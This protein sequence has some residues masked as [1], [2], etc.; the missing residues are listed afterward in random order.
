MM[1]DQ[2]Y[3][4]S[5]N[6][7]L[8]ILLNTLS[9]KAIVT[10]ADKDGKI[11]FVSD[12]FC[13]ISKFTKEELVGLNFAEINY[14][15]DDKELWVNFWETIKQGHIWTGE[16]KNKTKDGILYWVECKVHPIKNS[17]G[18]L[19]SFLAIKEDITEKRNNEISDYTLRAMLDHI[20]D[21]N[22]LIDRNYKILFINKL[23]RLYLK[24]QLKKSINVQDNI[25]DFLSDNI[26]SEFLKLFE[27][28][29][30]GGLVSFNKQ[31]D[32]SNNY[33][34]WVNIQ[35]SSI[36][37]QNGKHIGVAI[38]ITNI[39]E[40]IKR[41]SKLGEKDLLN[42]LIVE[43]AKIGI[44]LLDIDGSVISA[45][46]EAC[47]LLNASEI[48]LKT[49]NR[50]DLFAESDED[51]NALIKT[52]KKQ[53]SYNGFLNFRRK[54]GSTIFCVVN[55]TSFSTDTNNEIA[56]VIFRDVTKEKNLEIELKKKQINLEAL[57]NNTED[58]IFSIDTNYNIIEFNIILYEIA[59]N[60]NLILQ[61]GDSIFLILRPESH[62][63]FKSIYHKVLQ[64]KIV[65]DLEQFKKSNE[66]NLTYYETNYH[67]IF[68]DEKV[69]GISI[70]SKNVT[71]RINSEQELKNSQVALLKS[72]F[73]LKAI[74]DS[75][76]NI[77]FFIGPDLKV[78]SYNKQAYVLV[79]RTF[80]KQIKRGDSMLE[81]VLMN[82]KEGFQNN[83]KRVLKGESFKVEKNTDLGFG[84][85]WYEFSYYPVN[86]SNNEILGVSFNIKNITD[87]KIKEIEI[88]NLSNLLEST[89][90][91]AKIGS[92]EFNLQTQEFFLTE[93]VYKI[94]ELENN[95]AEKLYHVYLNR[96]HP[97][98]IDKL[99][100]LIDYVTKNSIKGEIVHRVNCNNN[101]IKYIN[102]YLTPVKDENGAVIIIR[103]LVKDITDTK[104]NE[105]D[106]IESK[107]YNQAL[108][109]STNDVQILL[110][111]NCKII[112]F[113]K[114]AAQTTY[115]FTR[116]Q[117]EKNSYML[118]YIEANEKDAFEAEF[119]KALNGEMVFNSRQIEVNDNT[120]FIEVAFHP[121]IENNLVK[122]IAYNFK[123]VSSLKKAEMEKNDILETLTNTSDNAPGILYQ[124]KLDQNR[125]GSYPFLSKRF[126]DIFDL[127]REALKK[128]ANPLLSKIHQD[129]IKEFNNSIA[130]SAKNLTV[131]EHEFRAIKNN[132][133]LWLKGYSLPQH[134]PNGSIVWSGNFYDITEEKTLRDEFERLSLVARHT[135]NA[136]IMTNVK[137]EIEWVNEGYTKI[138]G[139]SFKEAIG[140]KLSK[141]LQFEI[142]DENIKAFIK[143]QLMHYKPIQCEILNVGK[144]G[145]VYWLD[146]DIQAL[147]DKFNKHIGY[148]IIE[149]DITE[150]KMLE[151]TLRQRTKLL[152]DSNRLAKIGSWQYDI[153]TNK[154]IW[155]NITKQIHEIPLDY[156]PVVENAITFYKNDGSREQIK[157]AFN[158]LLDY[159]TTYDLEI[160][161]ITP[162]G[163]EKWVRTI[164]EAHFEGDKCIRIFGII[165]DIDKTKRFQ[166]LV[167]AKE[168]AEKSNKIKSEFLANMSHE[169]RTPMNAILGFADLLKGN[170][171]SP[172]YDKYVEN[173]SLGGKSLMSLINDILDLSKIEADKIFINYSE[174]DLK[175]II[176]ELKLIFSYE[177]N[178]QNN[179]IEISYS[180]K[181]PKHILIDDIRLR[182]ILFNI[183]GNAIKYTQNGKIEITVNH[184]L[185]ET[186][187]NVMKTLSIS[188]LDSGIGIPSGQL[189]LIFEPFKQVAHNNYKLY[190][191]T[192][193]GL[194]ISKRLT[195]LMGGILTVKS[196][197][198][199]GSE[200][201]ITFKNI[202]IASSKTLIKTETSDLHYFDLK[203]ISILIV[204]DMISNREILKG[205]LE[206]SNVKIIEAENG[207]IALN[208]LESTVPDIILLDMMMPVKNGFETSKEIREKPQLDHSKII[209]ISAIGKNEDK[210]MFK[211]CDDYIRK[212]IN[213]E[214]LLEAIYKNIHTIQPKVRDISQS[215]ERVLTEI[216]VD[217]KFNINKIKDILKQDPVKIQTCI[218]EYKKIVE[219]AL[220]VTKQELHFKN[221]ENLRASFHE[222]LNI[223]E[224]L[225][226]N[227]LFELIKEFREEHEANKKLQ[228]LNLIDRE[229]DLLNNFFQKSNLWEAQLSK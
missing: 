66:D 174:T 101:N 104:L 194:S 60:Q 140:K 55:V 198:N 105:L 92:W 9:E 28:A 216:K 40:R 75:T 49:K 123:D 188:I 121:V 145:N 146:I 126:N 156:T 39:D 201:T 78:I 149:T 46:P 2:N 76:D 211:Y 59:Y 63:K 184:Q 169:I 224:Y 34:I 200:F 25:L 109:D 178:C 222:L 61:K 125:N 24:K 177:L 6:P 99:N 95:S 220:E 35:F 23:T 190:G 67:P 17:S 158:K 176:E 204:E 195:N 47:E 58:I 19:E 42:K 91:I 36:Y 151:D 8:Q 62:D 116:K 141:L 57:I 80:N 79:F 41:E 214:T 94:F 50:Y 226:A 88:T 144:H 135:S 181:F 228:I 203:G 166:D 12:L 192:G 187:K 85:Y 173:I 219:I 71:A 167:K 56:T 131:W 21:G 98:D 15:P 153:E 122:F 183:I 136:V 202:R 96:I 64:G 1:T 137:Q 165:Q 143:D 168:D 81:F 182:Q 170:T 87:R 16:F 18:T 152:L 86:N 205:Y 52:L 53:Y 229:L 20:S 4:T 37:A 106:L 150:R 209:A 69:I 54:D 97:E 186:K 43:N 164:G 70:F 115:A 162:T 197:E 163:K 179:N 185:S 5:E 118:D 175:A 148:A 142:I 161:I 33:K 27:E 72:Q 124:Y 74:L 68:S 102:C 110:S 210:E 212:P 114:T 83:F 159:G 199:I 103:G 90:S 7:T 213:K 221:F 48:E 130:E 139:Y 93:E 132:K 134:R 127:D 22:I 193:L 44:V 227:H 207:D 155:D 117:L 215:K 100:E 108:L 128:D 119:K 225:N 217:N 189:E 206:D 218:N 138:T 14:D 11:T 73:E 160:I 180:D 32:F 107:M 112:T 120:Y 208:I 30:T 111:T 45:N 31:I 82:E 77:H 133:I 172:K 10:I 147:Y 129:D 3:Y 191:G 13:Q 154:L 113:S 84:M 38:S 196:E 171:I 26:K 157:T 29:S 223:C 65:K 89:N 51:I